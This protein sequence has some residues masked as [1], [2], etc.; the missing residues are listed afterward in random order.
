MITKYSI[1][2]EENVYKGEDWR[3]ILDYLKAAKSVYYKKTLLYQ[4]RVDGSQ[5]ESKYKKIP[6]LHNL[7]S[8]QRKL[9]LNAEYNLGADSDTL[10]R[11]YST[12]V[13]E[14]RYIAKSNVSEDIWKIA[15]HDWSV[16]K[17]AHALAGL[18]TEDYHRLEISQKN[19][20]YSFF[21]RMKCDHIARCALTF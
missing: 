20:L 1:F 21:I 15:L 3:F 5:I 19:R 11:W 18:K 14:L 17:A 12:Q 13:D 4:Y 6:G 16:Q 8:I 9:N 10:F 7:G 2:F